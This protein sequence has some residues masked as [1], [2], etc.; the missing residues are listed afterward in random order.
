MAQDDKNYNKFAVLYRTNAQSRA[1][2]EALITRGIP[3]KI[4]GGL[5]I[6]HRKKNKEPITYLKP[7]YNPI[8][9]MTFK[10]NI[11]LPKRSIGPTTKKKL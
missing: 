3:Y 11:K 1:I 10:K 2:E 7:A 6:F 8:D 4:I 9:S 5:K